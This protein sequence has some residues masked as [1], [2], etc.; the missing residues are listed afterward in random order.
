MP[1]IYTTRSGDI[2]DAI[3][4]KQLGSCNHVEALIN[5][6]RQY[7]GTTIF[8]AGVKLTL[9]EISAASLSVLPPWRRKS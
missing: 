7:L 6:N 8:S 9:P 4:Y 5:A 3:A 1:E 2:W